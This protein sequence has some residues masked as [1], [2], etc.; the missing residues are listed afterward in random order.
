[1]KRIY[2][3]PATTRRWAR[4][5]SLWVEWIYTPNQFQVSVN[6]CYKR[7]RKSG[8]PPHQARYLIYELMHAGRC[9]RLGGGY[10]R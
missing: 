10:Y 1:M 4:T 6:D 9:T 2:L 5:P 7:L 3:F 8:M